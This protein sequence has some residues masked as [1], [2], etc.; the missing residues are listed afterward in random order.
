MKSSTALRRARVLV[1]NGKPRF[2]CSAIILV[3][4]KNTA[5]DKQLRSL[6]SLKCCTLETWLLENVPD[7]LIYNY[8]I[9]KEYRLAWIDWMIEG[10]EAVG[11]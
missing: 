3:G 9:V 8:A 1:K 7:D 2:V 5:V 11:D 4:G 6:F 10:Y